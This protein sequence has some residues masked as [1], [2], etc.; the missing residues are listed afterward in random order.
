M[1]KVYNKKIKEYNWNNEKHTYQ[2]YIIIKDFNKFF[3][4]IYNTI[5]VSKKTFFINDGIDSNKI[6]NIQYIPLKIYVDKNKKEYV[7]RYPFGKYYL[8]DIC[9]IESKGL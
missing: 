8:K 1:Y 4:G 9:Q 5:L 2:T 6:N 7:K 3:N